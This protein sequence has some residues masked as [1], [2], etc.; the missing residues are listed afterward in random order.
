MTPT[1]GCKGQGEDYLKDGSL[2][3]KPSQHRDGRAHKES[4]RNGSVRSD[5][6]RFKVYYVNGYRELGAVAVRIGD[7]RG[8]IYTGRKSRY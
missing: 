5:L 6:V 3:R 2:R 8:H 7:H 4:D 1:P